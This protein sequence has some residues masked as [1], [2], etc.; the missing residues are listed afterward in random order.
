MRYSTETIAVSLL[1]SGALKS[2]LPI[3]NR[4]HEWN[5]NRLAIDLQSVQAYNH[6][7]SVHRQQEASKIE[8]YS[9]DYQWSPS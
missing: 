8:Q 4:I 1:D 6:G 9:E 5:G 7:I 2:I 3:Y